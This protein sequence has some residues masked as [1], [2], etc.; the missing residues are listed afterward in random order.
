V[1]VV[2]DQ[3]AAAHGLLWSKLG[4]RGEVALEIADQ[5]GEGAR[6]AGTT[7]RSTPGSI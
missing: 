3:N 2:N 4:P 6:R 7:A 5:D 1:L